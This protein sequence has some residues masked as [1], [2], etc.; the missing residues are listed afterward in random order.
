[1]P[2]PQPKNPDPL[3]ELQDSLTLPPG[4]HAAARPT[5]PRNHPAWL[6]YVL[7]AI[8]GLL[9]AIYLIF[10]LEEQKG[11]R[12]SHESRDAASGKSP[13]EHRE[14]SPGSKVILGWPDDPTTTI[15]GPVNEDAQD[16]MFKALRAKDEIGWNALVISGRILLI[17]PETRALVL[18]SRWGSYEVRL[19]T[20]RHIGRIAWVAE[21]AVK[22]E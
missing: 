22:K 15:S 17:E 18:D 3:S 7:P 21:E 11:L 10:I 1:M 8:A 14:I 9:F 12:P 13:I 19:L 4:R 6:F 2:M 16:A 20:G 5:A